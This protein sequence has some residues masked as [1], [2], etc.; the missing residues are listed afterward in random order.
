MEERVLRGRRQVE[1]EPLGEAQ[2]QELRDL[3]DSLN[4][5]FAKTLSHIPHWYMR[6]ADDEMAFQYLRRAI[7]RYGVWGEFRGY[8]Y[9]YLYLDEFKY[10][11]IPPVPVINRARIDDDDNA[12]EHG[13]E[14]DGL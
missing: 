8:T 11:E 1:P 2:A 4:F 6:R 7:K 5:V 10:W 3:V 12:G 14:P 9:R 13:P